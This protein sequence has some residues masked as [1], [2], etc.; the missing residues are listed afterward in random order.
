MTTRTSTPHIVIIGCGPSGTSILDQLSKQ[1]E[2]SPLAARITVIDPNGPGGGL[3]FGAGP[4]CHILNLAA[5]V[6]SLDPGDPLAFVRWMGDDVA[7]RH[8]ADTEYPPR[9]VFGRYVTH[10][11]DVALARLRAAGWPADVIAGAATDIA[12]ATDGGYEVAVGSSTTIR[13]DLVVLALGHLPPDRFTDLA[14]APHHHPSPYGGPALDADVT[15]AVLGSRLSAI[16][17]V[18]VRHEADHRGRTTLVSRSGRLPSIIGPSE[19]YEPRVLKKELVGSL[20]PDSIAL[21]DLV[22]LL[23]SEIETATGRSLDWERVLAPPPTTAHSFLAELDFVE[24]GAQRPWQSVLIGI[25]PLVPALWRAL[26]PVGRT[27][28]LAGT[29]SSWM[30]YLAAFPLPSARRIG[31]LFRTDRLTVRG[32]FTGVQQTAEGW[33]LDL[34]SRESITADVIVDGT[35]PGYDL[36]RATSPLVRSL[37][38]SG[39]AVPSPWGGLEVDA[40]T[41]RVL[42]AAGLTELDRAG[43]YAVGDLTR[44]RFLATADV[45]QS[46]RQAQVLS[47]HLLGLVNRS[48]P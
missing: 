6:M 36:E 8:W 39:R 40:R 22:A 2:R 16:D 1:A 30:S 20:A 33:T 17:V 48:D 3:A 23:Q 5:P 14:G 34:G 43:I 29:Y 10:V 44:G 32:G 12:R 19:P 24:R 15:V 41:L 4:D 47:D 42:P 7:H 46:V 35:G 18:L 11:G 37:L 9:W 21:D 25:Y 28:F 27:D 38:A 45:G 31:D 13:A 26:D